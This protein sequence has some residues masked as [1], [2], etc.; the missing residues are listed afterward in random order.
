MNELAQFITGLGRVPIVPLIGFPG[1][2]LNK[3]T[4]KEALFDPKVQIEALLALNEQ[5]RPDAL[6]AMMDLT[7]EAE[8]LGCPLK[9]SENDPPA[10]ADGLFDDRADNDTISRVFKDRTAGGRMHLFAE[11]V[12]GL[13]DVLD[14]PVAAYVIGPLT[15]AGE[16]MG[17][18]RVMKSTRKNPA[19]LH[20]VL[21]N[22]TELIM[23]Y[24]NLLESAGARIICILEPSAMMIS[25]TLFNEFSG[26]YCKKI[27]SESITVMSVLHICGDTNH[28]IPE[29]EKVGADGLSLDKQVDLPKAYDT[30]HSQ[31]VLIGNID[32]VSIITF[33][34]ADTVKKKSTQLI[35]AMKGKP[36][37]ILSTG[38]D[39]PPNAPIENLKAMMQSNGF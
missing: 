29:M 24:I 6:F 21:S 15:L 25:P 18:S 37:F 19:V 32:P 26:R 20:Q 22:T 27:V 2:Q 13:S 34:D 36:N 33:E 38:C 4:V 35:Q 31:T 17:I 30:L 9:F 28:L 39:V 23:N 5:V 12:S 1:I 11:V 8:H 14:I 7:V 16:I 10:V 3:K